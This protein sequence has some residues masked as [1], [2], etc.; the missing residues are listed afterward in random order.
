MKLGAVAA[1]L[2]ASAVFLALVLSAAAKLGANYEEVVPYV[3]RPLDIRDPRPLSDVRIGHFV[4][5]GQLPRLAYQPRPDVRWPLLNQPYMTDHLSYG[6]VLLGAAGVDRLW[7]ARL[8][9]ASFGVVLIWLV[10]DIAQLLGLGRRAGLIAS[11]I[12]ATSLP[13]TFM[14]TWARF[15]ESLASF[16]PAV[17][18]WA[19]LRHAVDGRARWI[20][21]AVVV[22]A[23][24]V[25]G[26]LT[27][28]W[29]LLGLAVAAGLAGWRPPSPRRVVLP[30]VVSAVLFAPFVGYSLATPATGSE[31]GRRLR[32]IPDLFIGDTLPGTA[33]SLIQYLGS[34]GAGLNHVIRGV[35]DWPVNAV[36]QLLVVATLVW[37]MARTAA[38]GTRPRRRRLETQMLAFLGVVFLL[39][40]L[41]FRERRDYQFSLLVPLHAVALAAF[42]DWC[43]IRISSVGGNRAGPV[44]AALCGLV[45]AGNLVEQVGFERDL[46]DAGNAMFNLEVQ[47]QSAGWLVEHGVEH[48]VMVTFYAAGTYELLSDDAVRPVYAFPM[49]RRYRDYGGPA[50]E[51]PDARVAWRDLL[52][53]ESGET[54]YAVLPR[55][56]NPIE[57][58]HFDEPAIRAAL[59]AVAPAEIAA[60]FS[61]RRG[62]PLLEIWR[63]GS[64]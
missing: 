19:L 37:L 52:D 38:G 41:F 25:S 32:Y 58:N 39:V 56:V 11:A 28:L 18:L 31:I 12:A 27:A 50:A 64:D 63:I 46:G 53:S 55:G 61:N 34:W 15:D 13:L 62:E 4:T 42:I 49:F 43:V 3:L 47:R 14:Y 21:V 5:S 59:L 44:A 20:W 57:A 8:W 17:V 36:G 23:L 29:P 16:G 7:A 45:V 33:L 6:G 10:Y 30:A 26:K 2:A 24:A 1:L 51:A 9:H 60:V 40:A 54:L 48:P 22:A 35:S